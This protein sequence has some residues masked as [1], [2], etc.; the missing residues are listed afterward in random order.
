[1][2][3]CPILFLDDAK[4]RHDAIE[5]AFHRR[6]QAFFHEGISLFI[7]QVYTAEQARHAI[8]QKRYVLASLDHD[9]EL[10]KL[11]G[12]DYV[13]GYNVAEH[14]ALHTAVEMQPCWVHIHSWNMPGAARMH[15]VLQQSC[16]H[17]LTRSPFESW[18][19]YWEQIFL[20]AAQYARNNCQA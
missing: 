8:T 3:F 14:I 2:I 10:S 1:M 19:K 5:Y 6:Q 9:L 13:S 4:E 18:L 11:E 7:D 15:M 16:V 20:Q 12:E 17:F